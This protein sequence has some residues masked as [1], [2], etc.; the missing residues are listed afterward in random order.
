MRIILR[1]NHLTCSQMKREKLGL[2]T[3]RAWNNGQSTDNIW[4][5][6]RVDGSTFRL[7]SHVDWSHSIRIVLKRNWIKISMLFSITVVP[8]V[9]SMWQVTVY[10]RTTIWNPEWNVTRNV[11]YNLCIETEIR[12]HALTVT[13]LTIFSLLLAKQRFLL[14]KYITPVLVHG[15]LF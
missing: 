10:C 14:W 6:W 8:V 12:V 3:L 4:T 9:N 13:T 1:A 2:L 7:A 11:V 5:D 15:P